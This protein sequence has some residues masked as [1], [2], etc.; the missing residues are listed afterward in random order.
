M[1][2]KLVLPYPLPHNEAE[3]HLVIYGKQNSRHVVLMCPG[4]PDD[5][6]TFAPLAAALA[7]NTHSDC[8]LG[9]LCLPGYDRD[10][11]AQSN[12]NHH[13]SDGY[14]FE[15]WTAT[16][17]E[18]TKALLSHCNRQRKEITVTGIFHDWGVIAGLQYT[19]QVIEEDAECLLLNQ[20]VLLDVLPRTH[21]QTKIVGARNTNES[22]LR[23]DSIANKLRT[24]AYQI[25]MS[26]TFWFQE[27][28]PL[29]CVCFCILIGF[30]VLRWT[31][32][33]PANDR[34]FQYLEETGILPIR[35]DST[36][37]LS[38][39]CYP[40][41]NVRRLVRAGTVTSFLDFATLPPNLSETPVLFLYGGDKWI[42]VHDSAA[43]ALI[44]Q[45]H[46]KNA[47]KSR[48]VRVEGAGHWLHHS[49]QNECLRQI[50][51]FLF[52]K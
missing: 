46:Q 50:Q 36:K 3:G 18:A 22:H 32:C 17:R 11:D 44:E 7:D 41:R 12:N 21:P 14:S 51:S 30:H 2:Q 8:L 19:N 31:R 4:F 10:N 25:L 48:A 40:Y 37:R 23:A 1:R 28:L 6:E 42:D 20:V 27:N 38:Y 33:F 9:V 45:E 24:D 35:L 15:D 34:D 16:L 39:I 43:L 13:P 49:H 29:W 47:S 52:D 26:W 5:Q